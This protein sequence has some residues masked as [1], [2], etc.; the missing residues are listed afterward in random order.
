[1]PELNSTPSQ[2]NKHFLKD[3]GEMG[4]LT[5][6]KDWSKTSLGWTESWP[7]SLRTSK[8]EYVGTG[9]GLAIVKRIVENHNG[10]ISTKGELNK[11]ATFDI[12]I[13]SS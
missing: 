9:I 10:H 5:R 11:G 8:R 3:E 6:Q 12:N 1:M 13:P 7:Q 4:E 2:N